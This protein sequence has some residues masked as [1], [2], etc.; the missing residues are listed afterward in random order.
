MDKPE[1][2]DN[3]SSLSSTVRTL[4][5]CSVVLS[6]LLLI[7]II[8]IIRKRIQLIARKRQVPREQASQLNGRW[9]DQCPNNMTTA[10][11]V[12]RKSDAKIQLQPVELRGPVFEDVHLINKK[13]NNTE[14]RGKQE[15][16]HEESLFI[17][18]HPDAIV[19]DQFPSSNELTVAGIPLQDS[20]WMFL[21]SCDLKY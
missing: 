15:G 17:D 21:L 13:E 11:P 12:I 19:N 8:L 5:G 20:K 4:L 18:R 2:E 1:S 6:I 10:Q 16:F 9:E 7:F 14:Q 3:N